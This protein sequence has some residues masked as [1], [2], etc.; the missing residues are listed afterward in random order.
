MPFQL[1][2]NPI[3]N[4]EE[5]DRVFVSGVDS[6]SCGL[7]TVTTPGLKYLLDKKKGPGT[8]KR[9]VTHRGTDGADI[10][11]K[12]RMWTGAQFDAWAEYQGLFEFDPTKKK[13]KAIEIEHPALL[14]LNLRTFLTELI[15]PIID[16]G[17][18]LYSVTVELTEYSP[19][20]KTNVTK[21]PDGVQFGPPSNLAG[22]LT[23]ARS[24]SERTRDQLLALANTPG[25]RL[26]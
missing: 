7:V 12:F 2:A 15:G 25:G 14:F 19:P 10:K 5:F 9:A 4:P 1:V 11:L 8:Q 26:P 18:G 23:D 21:T 6:S 17:K 20:P 22:P 13:F 24:E 16:E 3:D